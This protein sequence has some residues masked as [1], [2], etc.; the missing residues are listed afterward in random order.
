LAGEF[1]RNQPLGLQ[2]LPEERGASTLINTDLYN[3]TAL[4]LIGKGQVAISKV[5]VFAQTN[6]FGIRSGSVLRS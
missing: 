2:Q 6:P 5:A 4:K 3:A 1:D